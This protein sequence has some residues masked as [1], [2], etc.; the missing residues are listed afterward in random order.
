MSICYVCYNISATE[1][2]LRMCS[3]HIAFLSYQWGRPIDEEAADSDEDEF[4]KCIHV[5][6]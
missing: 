4:G 2:L 1:V 5:L 6:Y 3:Y